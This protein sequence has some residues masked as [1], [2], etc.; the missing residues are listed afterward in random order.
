MTS[1]HELGVHLPAFEVGS[2]SK[3]TVPC[4]KMMPQLLIVR[5]Y[6]DFPHHLG[7]E[8]LGYEVAETTIP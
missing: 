8:M 3:A 2:C 7:W 4:S 6:L 5:G 1:R